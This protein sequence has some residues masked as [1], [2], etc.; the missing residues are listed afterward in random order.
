[1]RRA[2]PQADAEEAM[3]FP[4][5]RLTVAA[6]LFVA[7]LLYL[8]SLVIVSR[9]TVVLSRPQILVADLTVI[10]KVSDEGGKPSPSV[11]VRG[12]M[13][14]EADEVL[15][16][17]TIS[18]PNLPAAAHQGYAGPG[19]YIVPL[20]KHVFKDT[21]QYAVAALPPPAA[22]PF[23]QPAFYNVVVYT[24]PGA[25]VNAARTARLAS[26]YLD[27]NAD[28]AQAIIKDIPP[29]GGA[30]LLA[31]EVR[32]EKAEQFKKALGED[33]EN[34]LFVELHASDLRIYPLTP[35]TQEQ[36]DEIRQARQQEVA[37]KKS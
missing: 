30:K 32:R 11:E 13:G 2:N 10:A 29:K 9:Q 4:R 36:L 33:M 22:S 7:W 26:E 8:L 37:E 19:V 34:G 6:T 28:E 24:G 25:N 20:R 21:V 18:I 1:M 5:A 14:D 15:I 31:H 23:Y 3:T 35:E 16:G 27:V 12:F 17:K